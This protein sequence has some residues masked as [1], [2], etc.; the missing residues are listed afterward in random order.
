MER[1]LI[2]LFGL[3]AVFILIMLRVPVALAMLITGIV[4]S[5]VISLASPFLKFGPYL[6]QFKTALWNSVANYDLTVIPLFI[7]MGLLASEGGLSRDLFKGIS[8]LTRNIRGGVAMATIGACAGFGAVSGS[9]IATASTMKRVQFQI[10][11]FMTSLPIR[12][13]CRAACRKRQP[14]ERPRRSRPWWRTPWP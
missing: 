12:K 13:R 1:E 3:L 8:V 11:L 6:L 9:S 4:G 2:G 14:S 7:L 5:W 10:L